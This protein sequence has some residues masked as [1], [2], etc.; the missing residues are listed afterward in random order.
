MQKTYNQ[1]HH[2]AFNNKMREKSRYLEGYVKKYTRPLTPQQKLFCYNI[3]TFGSNNTQ[4]YR[5][6]YNV[7]TMSDRCVRNEAYKLAKQ[8]KIQKEIARLYSKLSEREKRIKA[9]FDPLTK[10]QIAFIDNWFCFLGMNQTK[11]YKMT[12][13]CSNMSD[14]T[15]RN[16]AYL[17]MQNSKIIL[18]LRYNQAMLRGEFR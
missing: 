5:N 16:K 18:L 10:K 12:Y 3:I 11:A 2:M 4:A 17:L 14:R 13:D 6:S 9:I 7:A 15:I 8:P 1:S